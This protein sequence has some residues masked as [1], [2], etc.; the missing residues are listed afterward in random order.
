[1]LSANESKN[2]LSFYFVQVP[3][4]RAANTEQTIRRT[5][6]LRSW[7]AGWKSGRESGLKSSS[8]YGKKI[9][10]ISSVKVFSFFWAS[11]RRWRKFLLSPSEN[12]YRVRSLRWDRRKKKRRK[13]CRVVFLKKA[14]HFSLESCFPY[15]AGGKLLPV[16]SCVRDH[17]QHENGLV[18]LLSHA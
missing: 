1:M 13:R 18:G 4:R 16:S 5:I 3:P 17:C 2:F 14:F 9:V 11:Y 6:L 15:L 10:F 7:K 8:L 12:S